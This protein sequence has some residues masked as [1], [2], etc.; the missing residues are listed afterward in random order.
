[1]HILLE[2]R[3]IFA[4]HLGVLLLLVECR[5]LMKNR[6]LSLISGGR[7]THSAW[8][9]VLRRCALL[10]QIQLLPHLLLLLLGQVVV[11]SYHYWPPARALVAFLGST[12][13]GLCPLSAGVGSEA[14]AS[15]SKSPFSACRRGHL[16]LNK[17]Q[18]QTSWQDIT[19]L[20]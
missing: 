11:L 1:M 16:R 2:M 20:S 4:F 10:V 5:C 17:L 8:P 14:D 15:K 6:L 9:Q 12:C 7:G 18:I 19:L 13:L 3:L